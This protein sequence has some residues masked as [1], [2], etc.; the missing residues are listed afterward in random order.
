MRRVLRMTATSVLYSSILIMSDFSLPPAAQNQATDRL[1]E[2][3][4]HRGEQQ[5][6]LVRPPFT[7]ACP[8]GEQG[9]QLFLDAIFVSPRA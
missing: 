5:A 1:H 6:E 4:G 7:A 9:K 2:N 8:V 3:E